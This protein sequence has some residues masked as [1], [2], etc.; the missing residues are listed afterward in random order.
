MKLKLLFF[1]CSVTLFSAFSSDLYIL[2]S[3]EDVGSYDS[4]LG[5]SGIF[6]YTNNGDKYVYSGCVNKF[7]DKI[8]NI[9]VF[10][11]S[12]IAIFYGEINTNNY[13][14]FDLKNDESVISNGL[15]GLCLF[16][17]CS[18]GD[19]SFLKCVIRNDNGK[20]FS[21]VYEVDSL[22]GDVEVV[23]D[24]DFL[25]YYS[26]GFYELSG[27]GFKSCILGV[28]SD[29]ICLG[30]NGLDSNVKKIYLL[31][32]GEKWMY[33]NVFY[34]DKTKNKDVAV[35]NK[36]NNKLTMYKIGTGVGKFTEY[37]FYKDSAALKHNFEFDNTDIHTGIWTLFVNGVKSEV[38]LGIDSKILLL[39]DSCLYFSD[40]ARLYICDV[41]DNHPDLNTTKLLIQDD[42]IRFASKLLL[43]E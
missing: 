1:I 10:Y 28:D 31:S 23:S 11:K 36:S 40:D 18:S 19:N 32:E 20:Y 21:A 35:F 16:A 41:T 34:D 29:L 42:K 2:S 17:E 25:K 3:G 30:G 4:T 13:Y 8:S 5:Y 43:K 26:K 22:T 39:N 7:Q 14:I 9:E 24:I 27:D 12:G 6:K 37:F 15:Q 33:F 38:F